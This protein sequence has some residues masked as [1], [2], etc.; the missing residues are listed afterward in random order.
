MYPIKIYSQ[1]LCL[2]EYRKGDLDAHHAV[3][4]N[5]ETMY[6]MPAVQTHSYEQSAANLNAAIKAAHAAERRQ[7]FLVIADKDDERYLGGIGYEVVYQC[8]AGKQVEIGYFLDDRWQGKGY[9]TE[10]LRSLIDFAFKEDDVYRINGTCMVDNIASARVMEK[11]GMA[12]EGE[13]VDIEWHDGKLINRYL[14]RLILITT[15]FQ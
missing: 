13:L 11:C 10:A 1:R 7:V 5:A 8:S 4:S 12:R 3:I 15:Q 14:Y 2:R 9:A 6:Y